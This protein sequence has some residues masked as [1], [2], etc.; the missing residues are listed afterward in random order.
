MFVFEADDALVADGNSKNVARQV[1]QG[2]PA[3]SDRLDVVDPIALPDFLRNLLKQLPSASL[4][5]SFLSASR[6]LARRILATAL[7]GMR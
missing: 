3:L 1:F 7:S 2:F 6:N 5:A 4:R